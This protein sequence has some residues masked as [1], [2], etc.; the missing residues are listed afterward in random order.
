MNGQILTRINEPGKKVKES[1]KPQKKSLLIGIWKGLKA[2]QKELLD[3]KK[4][5]FDFDVEKYVG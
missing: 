3:A 4:S 5:P 1:K 2:N